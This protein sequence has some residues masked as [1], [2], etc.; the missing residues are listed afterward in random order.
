MTIRAGE[1]VYNPMA[2]GM[3]EWEHAPRAYWESPGVI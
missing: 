2:L 3:P 1:I